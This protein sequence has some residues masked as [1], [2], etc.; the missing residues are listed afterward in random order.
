MKQRGLLSLLLE[1][2]S[3]RFGCPS[4]LVLFDIMV[5]ICAGAS[6]PV[7]NQEAGSRKAGLLSKMAALS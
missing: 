7:S 3:S 2:P 4:G 6:D 1:V 5:G